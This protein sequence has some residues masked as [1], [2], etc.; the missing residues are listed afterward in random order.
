MSVDHDNFSDLIGQSTGIF[1]GTDANI[2]GPE[3]GLQSFDK[4]STTPTPQGV[5]VGMS[6]RG[7]GRPAQLMVE[8]PELVAIKYGVSPLYAFQGMSPPPLS[9]PIEWRYST[10][11]QGW[12]PV[13]TCG[14]C[15]TLCAPIF[16]PEEAEAHLA[17]ARRNGWTRQDAEKGLSEIA[18]RAALAL[19]QQR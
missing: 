10:S 13:K 15:H 16:S 9:E 5:A 18:Y 3:G 6:C 19:S 1:G 17:R 12:F 4:P 2:A 14:W 7:C 8:Y 11:Q